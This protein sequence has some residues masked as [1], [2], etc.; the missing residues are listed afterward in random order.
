[1]RQRQRSLEECARFL[2]RRVYTVCHLFNNKDVFVKIVSL[3][4]TMHDLVRLDN[5]ITNKLLRTIFLEII[6]DNDATFKGVQNSH[7]SDNY[8]DWLGLRQISVKNI[9]C[10]VE[11]DHM[12]LFSAISPNLES[13]HLENQDRLSESKMKHILSRVNLKHLSLIECPVLTLSLPTLLS[14]CPQLI[15]LTTTEVCPSIFAGGFDCCANLIN[16]DLDFSCPITDHEMSIIAKN[17]PALQILCLKNNFA[18][19]DVTIETVLKACRFLTQIEVVNYDQITDESLAR[20]ADSCNKRLTKLVIDCNYYSEDQLPLNITDIGLLAIAEK[21]TGLTKLTLSHCDLITDLSI[22]SL[23]HNLGKTLTSI[24]LKACD[25]VT[26]KELDIIANNCKKLKTLSIRRCTNVTSSGVCFLLQRCHC[27]EEID[28]YG[29]ISLTA[30]DFLTLDLYKRSIRLKKLHLGSS[31][32]DD[33]DDNNNDEYYLD[34]AFVMAIVNVFDHIEDLYLYGVDDLTDI[35]ISNIIGKCQTIHLPPCT[36][37]G[38][39]DELIDILH[40]LYK[41]SGRRIVWETEG[42]DA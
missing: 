20:I 2:R 6:S 26:N 10:N 34:N 18:L 21:C 15:S 22:Q 12:F 19:T 13:L 5:S 24:S 38:I 3:F 35:S 23:T 11:V 14:Y 41:K 42:Y 17:C 33:D 16:L 9:Y 29:C 32:D 8:L 25:G 27:L 37:N 30:K 7:N 36:A 4:L 1:M 31:A 28:L 39:S 40:E